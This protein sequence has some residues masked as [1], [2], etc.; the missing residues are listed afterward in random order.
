MISPPPR[1]QRTD[2]V[3]TSVGCILT[4]HEVDGSVNFDM[5]AGP[6]VK[7]SRR[8]ATT[9]RNRAVILAAARKVFASRGY[10]AATTREI[11]RLTDLASG[12]FYEY[13]EDKD[14]VFAAVMADVEVDLVRRYRA[15]RRDRSLPLEERVRRSCAAFFAFVSENP[16]LVQLLELSWRRPAGRATDGYEVGMR[17]LQLDFA[18]ELARFREPERDWIATSIIGAASMCALR[19]QRQGLL[20]PRGPTRA[21]T[22]LVLSML[23]LSSSS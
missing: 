23:T 1:Y 16:D 6:P 19:M 7:L 17:K 20:D 13:F 14:D 21:L 15:P 2:V 9:T 10:E 8:E 11:M 12:T 18:Q 4:R 5:S 22:R 3:R